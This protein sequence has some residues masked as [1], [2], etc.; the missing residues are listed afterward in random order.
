MRISIKFNSISEG[1]QL[2]ILSYKPL[3]IN[4]IGK[5]NITQA[6]DLSKQY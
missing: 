4:L 5:L 3:S 6:T 2:T 1:I